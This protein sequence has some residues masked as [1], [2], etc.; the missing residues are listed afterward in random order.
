MNEPITR[1]F[2]EARLHSFDA[3]RNLLEHR[4]LDQAVVIPDLFGKIRVVVWPAQPVKGT[5]EELKAQI[6]QVMTEAAGPFWSN[7]I[8]VAPG[9]N[10]ADRR[11]YAKVLSEASPV[12][13]NL[14]TDERHRSRGVWFQSFSDP[15]WPYESPGAGLEAGPPIISFYSFKGGLGRTTA[16]AA[17]AIQRARQGEEVLVVDL[18]LGAPGVGALL[19]PESPVPQARWGVVDYLLEQ[20][21]L[22]AAGLPIDLAD[23]YHICARRGVAEQG[24]I[25]VIPAGFL[26]R[27]YL[28]KLARLDMEPPQDAETGHPLANLLRQVR[29][30]LKPDWILLDSRA[31]LSEAAGFALGGVAHLNILFGT[32]SE[33]SWQGL[34]IAIEQLGAKRLRLKQPQAPCLLVQ[35]MAPD[36]GDSKAQARQQFRAQADWAFQEHYYAADVSGERDESVWYLSDMDSREAPHIPVRLPYSPGLAYFS[37]LSAVADELAGRSGDY[38]ELGDKIATHFHRG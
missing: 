4:M 16:L 29:E 20:P 21:V 35:G 34:A 2:D 27:N 30:E 25:R 3:M 33:Q 37:D 19:A 18:D 32:T 7:D 10:E 36:I 14:F 31:G 8:W 13:P 15:P 26:D 24:V 5:T 9:T 12:A 6:A 28:G 38:R 23:Y 17:F 1:H 22:S 11:L